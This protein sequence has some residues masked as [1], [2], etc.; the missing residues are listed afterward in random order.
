MAA[1]LS[2]LPPMFYQ[3]LGNSNTGIEYHLKQN[4]H[5]WPLVELANSQFPV[6]G[7]YSPDSN[8]CWNLGMSSALNLIIFSCTCSVLEQP[9][10]DPSET[11]VNRIVLVAQFALCFALWFYLYQSN[12]QRFPW[13]HA[14]NYSQTTACCF[15]H[16][17][18]KLGT[19]QT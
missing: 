16:V 3:L 6:I 11:L 7:I 13:L 14:V 9:N 1:V 19:Q 12:N 15:T 2:H 10:L 18:R 5:S 17:H 8:H 4:A